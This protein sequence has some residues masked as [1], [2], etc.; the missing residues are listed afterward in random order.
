MKIL[1]LNTQAAAIFASLARLL[2]FQGQLSRVL[3]W[4]FVLCP[5]VTDEAGVPQRAQVHH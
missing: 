3:Q 4:P 1:A 2:L 5:Y